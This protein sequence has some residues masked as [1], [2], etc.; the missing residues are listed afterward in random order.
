MTL[1]NVLLSAVAAAFLALPAS[2]S[3]LVEN[4]GWQDD[5]LSAANSTTDNSP[6]TFTIADT[7]TFSVVDCCVVG[8]VYKL[9]D[10]ATLLK[11]STFYAGSGVQAS[12]GY[13]SF[14][15]SPAYSK[16]A[17]AVGPGSYSFTIVGDG[18]GGIPAGL[19]VRLDSGA[20]PE[21]STWAMMLMGFGGLGAMLRRTRRQAVAA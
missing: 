10:G 12:G 17:F 7:A 8:D 15:T 14:W 18:V 4:T 19:G 6:W 16:L 21:A 13:G 1:R 9:Y 5:I 20:V 2:A 3:V 11:T